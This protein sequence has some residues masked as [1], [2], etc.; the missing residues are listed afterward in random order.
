MTIYT[1][2]HGT[3]SDKVRG[4]VN[5]RSCCLKVKFHAARKIHVATKLMEVNSKLFASYKK[6]ETTEIAAL[7][8]LS[9]YMAL[10][11]Y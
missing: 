9:F 3:S 4:T 2:T 11:R 6:I 7:V 10:H 8:S 5:L 1:F